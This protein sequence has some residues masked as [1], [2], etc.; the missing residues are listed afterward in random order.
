M[1][2]SYYSAC[3]LD[4]LKH[5]IKMFRGFIE[6]VSGIYKKLFASRIIPE[7]NVSICKRGII[8]KIDMG[9]LLLI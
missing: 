4:A 6:V 5:A 2:I 3:G 9:K 7:N 8:G 1:R